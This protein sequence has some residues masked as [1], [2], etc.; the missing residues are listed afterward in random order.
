M[1][2][3]VQS[4]SRTCEWAVLLAV[5]TLALLSGCKRPEPEDTRPC[6]ATV[7]I[8]QR[9]GVDVVQT[10]SGLYLR[11][12]IAKGWY[13]GS[14]PDSRHLITRGTGRFFWFE[15][16]L[17][18]YSVNENSAMISLPTIAWGDANTQ[19]KIKESIGYK[20]WWYQPAIPHKLYPLDLL[21]NWAVDGGPDP[22]AGVGIIKRSPPTWAVRGTVNP[23]GK[24]PFTTQCSMKPPPEWDGKD[25]RPAAT[26]ELDPAWLIQAA[27]SKSL[28][29]NTCR[30][31]VSADNG[32]FIGATIDV[33]GA[34]VPDIDKIYKLVGQWLAQIIVE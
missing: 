32:A 12:S 1:H 29:F 7:K 17:L 34:A 14:T 4:A 19:A 16:K 21:P 8:T 2:S 3:A 33:P 30:G 11:A 10:D 9:N 18:P 6:A 15:G 26:K 13:C 22:Q 31:G 25:Y 27:T 5:L 28:N 23:N 20:D 24:K